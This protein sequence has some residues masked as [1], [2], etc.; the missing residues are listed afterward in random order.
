MKYAAIII[1]F[2]FL[3]TPA[4][5]EEYTLDLERGWNMISTPVDPAEGGLVKTNIID[6]CDINGNRI[7]P[8]ENIL[9]YSVE[10]GEYI[11]DSVIKSTRGYFVGANSDCQ[12]PYYGEPNIPEEL[13]LKRGWNMIS[14]GGAELTRE[15]IEA[16]CGPDKIKGDILHYD[17]NLGDYRAVT[18]LSPMNGYYI[19]MLDDCTIGSEA[20]DT[21]NFDEVD[22]ETPNEDSGENNR[23]NEEIGGGVDPTNDLDSIN[24]VSVK[25][26]ENDEPLSEAEVSVGGN[27]GI[28][29]QNGNTDIELGDEDILKGNNVEIKV[30]GETFKKEVPIDLSQNT[31]EVVLDIGCNENQAYSSYLRN[32]EVLDSDGCI[33]KNSEVFHESIDERLGWDLS[34]SKGSIHQLVRA[35]GIDKTDGSKEL[36]FNTGQKGFCGKL[37]WESS[38][39]IISEVSIEDEGGNHSP[40]PL[41][42]QTRSNKKVI[43][44]I[45][46]SKKYYFT[47]KNPEE[48]NINEYYSDAKDNQIE[49]IDLGPRKKIM[50]GISSLEGNELAC[51]TFSRRIEMKVNINEIEG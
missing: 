39:H 21:T 6:E 7:V 31:F 9:T 50:I 19:G 47:T 35:T 34:S 38:G 29:N 49:R 32:L 26:L 16:E 1:I 46:T 42:V 14:P 27:S 33:E 20:F 51:N 44:D 36:D 15:E 11:S 25:A 3:F 40:P 8:S 22:D 23:E 10:R 48:I 18:S 4:A 17:V 30:N 45:N 2:T 43:E 5:S 13:E 12:V 28:T 37:Y 41:F 24:K